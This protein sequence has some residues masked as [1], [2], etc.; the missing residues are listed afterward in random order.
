MTAPKNHEGYGSFKIDMILNG[1]TAE[2]MK[3]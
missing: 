1:G 3:D 2:F